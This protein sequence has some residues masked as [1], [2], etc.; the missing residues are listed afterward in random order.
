MLPLAV[1]TFT[2]TQQCG[3]PESGIM[4]SHCCIQLALARKSR[5]SYNAFGKAMST[6][7]QNVN[8]GATAQIPLYAP[9]LLFP[10]SELTDQAF[11]ECADEIDEG[12]GVWKT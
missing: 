12:V 5:A 9:C 8:N 7:D 2:A 4:L 10:A 11:E 3:M 1:S 6:V